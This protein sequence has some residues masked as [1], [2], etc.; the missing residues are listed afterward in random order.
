MIERRPLW[1][2][3][4]PPSR[5]RIFPNGR[6]K[7]SVTTRTSWSGARSRAISLRTATPESFM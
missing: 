7:S 4:L 5:K 6:L 2:P 1:P 3:W